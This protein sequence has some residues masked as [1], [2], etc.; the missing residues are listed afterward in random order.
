MITPNSIYNDT[1]LYGGIPVTPGDFIKIF[2]DVER[3]LKIKR[4]MV[5]MEIEKTLYHYTLSDP[6]IILKINGTAVIVR[7]TKRDLSKVYLFDS[8]TDSF[9]GFANQNLLV[10]GDIKSMSSKDKFAIQRHGKKIRRIKNE[11]DKRLA[12]NTI[13]P[14]DDFFD[15]PVYQSKKSI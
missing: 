15:L 5:R 10:Y 12:Q 14:A 6:G 1:S 13:E 4:S 9:I 7:A 3:V 2:C 11:C 8:K